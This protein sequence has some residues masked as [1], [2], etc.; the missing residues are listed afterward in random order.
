MVS[1]VGQEVAAV[2]AE[3][4]EEAGSFVVAAVEP[5]NRLKLVDLDTVPEFEAWEAAV[6]AVVAAVQYLGSRCT[7]LEV[8]ASRSPFVGESVAAAD[9][10]EV[11]R[12]RQ[13]CTSLK[14]ISGWI[15][16]GESGSW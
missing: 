4:A 15:E 14:E 2:V 16:W 1:E 12:S 5:G 8:A 3:P 7:E 9:H 10:I 6:A 11:G 13:C